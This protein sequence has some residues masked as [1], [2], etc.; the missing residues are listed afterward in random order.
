MLKLVGIKRRTL[1]ISEVRILFHFFNSQEERREYG[2]SGFIEMQF[3]RLPYDSSTSTIVS[4]DSI[5]FWK[6][7][8]LYID[9]ENEFYQEYS[10]IFDCGIYNNQNTGVVDVYGINYYPPALIAPIISKI[11]QHTPK[12]YKL[13]VGWLEKAMQYNGFYILGL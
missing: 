12:E 1:N 5:K 7:D 11:L 4:V 2:G 6:L 9:D 13:L 10:H 8:S 3:C